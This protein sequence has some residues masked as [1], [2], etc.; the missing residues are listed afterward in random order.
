MH[1]T[2]LFGQELRRRGDDVDEKRLEVS[3]RYEALIQ[4]HWSAATTGA[5]PVAANTVMKVMADYTRLWGLDAATRV[6]L[7]VGISAEEFA[8]R[9]RELLA[10]TGDAP[11]RKLA[12]LPVADATYEDISPADDGWSNL[13][14]T[15]AAAAT[16]WVP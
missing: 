13:G 3:A 15:P 9:A 8:E 14:D 5:D 4:A 2:N 1:G 10:I 12:G 6:S 11:L 16:E 7:S